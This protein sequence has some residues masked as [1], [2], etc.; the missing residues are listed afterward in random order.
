LSGDSGKQSIP[1]LVLIVLISIL[2]SLQAFA[3]LPDKLPMAPSAS[4]AQNKF[5]YKQEIIVLVH[6]LMRTY[7]SMSPLKSYLEKQGYRVYYYK[8][9]SARYSIHEHALL[10]NEFIIK[11]LAENPE[12]T[13]HF[14]THSLGGIIVREALAQWPKEQLKKIGSLIMLAP[15]NQGSTLAKFSAKVFPMMTYFIKPLVELSSDKAAYVHHVP[16]PNIKMGIIAG[17]F[18]AKVPPS[19]ARLDGL[20]EPVVVNTTH[21]FIMNHGRTKELIKNFLEKGTF[22]TTKERKT[23]RHL[24]H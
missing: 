5:K 19:S 24:L 21:T 17:R 13:M 3:F 7:M 6:G 23:K 10:L 22:Y 11:L 18:D 9:P 14:I 15:P 8:Y 1:K 12:A 20:P 2:G 4:E 16:V